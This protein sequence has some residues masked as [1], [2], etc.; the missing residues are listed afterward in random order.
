MALLQCRVCYR[1]ADP[2]EKR[3]HRCWQLLSDPL[4]PPHIIAALARDRRT[5]LVLLLAPLA[6]CLLLA[7]ALTYALLAAE[8]NSG[9]KTVSVPGS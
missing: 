2:E 6:L 7:G 3:C 4:R 8:P 5:A 9:E 1:L